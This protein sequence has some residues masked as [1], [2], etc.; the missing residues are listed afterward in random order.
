MWEN[1]PEM[2]MY[3]LIFSR[4]EIEKYIKVIKPFAERSQ[5]SRYGTGYGDLIQNSSLSIQRITGLLID[6]MQLQI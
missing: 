2:I 6:Y 1:I 5:V 4:I 3:A